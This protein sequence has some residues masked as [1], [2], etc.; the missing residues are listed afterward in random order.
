M[1]KLLR[2]ILVLGLLY[3]GCRGLVD[4]WKPIVEES[5]ALQ[6]GRSISKV[7]L[8]WDSVDSDSAASSEM[9]RSA[10]P[11]RGTDFQGTEDVAWKKPA[12][13]ATPN[14]VSGR[15]E[16]VIY[17]VVRGDTLSEIAQDFFGSVLLGKKKIL[18]SN[19]GIREDRIDIG[20]QL[21][22][23]IPG[24]QSAETQRVVQ[25]SGTIHTVRDGETLSA[26]A[27]RYF[28]T[29]NYSRILEAN[30]QILSNPN[31]LKIG[32]KL[33]IPRDE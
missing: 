7:D 33:K 17:T 14:A 23:P 9:E 1:G 13:N 25:G 28:G 4:W 18:E 15:T 26:I 27:Q 2:W 29:E 30:R 22:I 11:F 31:R 8:R 12:P 16:T 3:I 6:D 19:P 20:Q 5:S 10:I 32:M 21:I 24:T